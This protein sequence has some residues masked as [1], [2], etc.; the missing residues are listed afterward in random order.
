LRAVYEGIIYSIYEVARAL[1]A[2]T[3]PIRVIYANGG[4]ARSPFWVQM[5]ADIFNTKVVITQTVESSAWGAALLGL[6]AIQTETEVENRAVPLKEYLP[7]PDQHASYM[8]IFSIFE[9][10]YPLL[11]D[12]MAAI[13]ALQD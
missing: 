3:G 11:K 12:Q 9:K 2:T 6:Q 5:L 13:S 1:I 7:N 4:F 8:Q 10:L